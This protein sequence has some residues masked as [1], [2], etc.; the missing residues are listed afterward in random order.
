[1]KSVKV[2]KGLLLGMMMFLVLAFSNVSYAETTVYYTATG[3]KYHYSKSCKGLSNA[4]HVYSGA[5][6]EAQGNGLTACAIC[7]GGTPGT[8]G[9]NGGTSLSKPSFSKWDGSIAYWQNVDK[10]DYY[11][12]TIY[13]YYDSSSNVLSVTDNTTNVYYDIFPKVKECLT[14][15]GLFGKVE[16][17]TASIGVIAKTNNADF[18]ESTEAVSST[19]WAHVHNF[20]IEN[21]VVIK[22]AT[23]L[24]QGKKTYTCP[25]CG[26]VK[27]EIIPAL[28][29]EYVV[30]SNKKATIFKEGILKKQCSRCRNVE[31]LTYPKLKSKVELT[32]K[33]I[34]IKV[35]NSSKIKIKKKTSGDKVAKWI[36]SNKRIVT[37]NNKGLV[38]GKSKGKTT[39]KV[40]MKS[41][42]SK[43]CNVI[44]E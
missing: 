7:S 30:T 18:A 4:K 1:M 27:D 33:K 40:V 24:E 14:N 17:I 42:C 37:V 29:H 34:I 12:V 13:I 44:V 23:C 28:G 15:N 2:V 11:K 43:K 6:S 8:G 21:A 3:T 26:K 31:N 38:K 20:P 19:T 36:T 39:I 22:E 10:A 16:N 32:K 41:G 9:D 25:I 5:L 35:G